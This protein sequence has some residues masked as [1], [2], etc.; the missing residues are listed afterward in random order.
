MV[1]CYRSDNKGKE[2]GNERVLVVLSMLYLGPHTSKY[3]VS[4]RAF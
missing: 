4:L 3:P 1:I 2:I